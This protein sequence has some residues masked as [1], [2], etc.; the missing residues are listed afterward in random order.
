[1]A[2]CKK[3]KGRRQTINIQ[4]ISKITERRKNYR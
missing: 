4:D 2:N 3:I 1:M